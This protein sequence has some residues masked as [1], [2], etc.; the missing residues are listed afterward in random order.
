[1]ITKQ[2]QELYEALCLYADNIVKLGYMHKTR[3]SFPPARVCYFD[4]S[5]VLTTGTMTAWMRY[6]IH[7]KVMNYTGR[8]NLP[9][10]G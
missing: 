10:R 2:T 9:Y 3:R 5:V 7:R 1:M 8:P 4:P 6:R